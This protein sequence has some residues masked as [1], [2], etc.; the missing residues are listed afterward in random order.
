[1]KKEILNY[2][3]CLNIRSGYLVTV[4]IQHLYIAKTNLE[5]RE[6]IFLDCNSHLCIDGQ[7]ALSVF[8]KYCNPGAE[9]VVGNQ[10][11]EDWLIKLS[12][13]D[14]PRVLVIGSSE[15]VLSKISLLY[16]SIQFV[17]IAT[18]FSKLDADQAKSAVFDIV[19][20]V[21]QKFQLV[22]V[23]LGVPKQELLAQA[24]AVKNQE[25]PILCI[26]GSFELISKIHKPAPA[27]FKKL[28]I[29]P[30]WRF[31]I[32][33]TRMRFVR[34]INSYYYFFLFLYSKK[35]FYKAIEVKPN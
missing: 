24:L 30:F 6:A 32:Q 35:S 21:G 26:G 7:G 2:Q 16:S 8:R 15:D 1:M 19:K 20:N 27:I 29:E 23:A 22:A 10:L 4:N 17:H 25:A 5:L 9:L 3:Q 13:L 31:L 18:E 33:P 14:R 34:L 11:L 12:R 28:R